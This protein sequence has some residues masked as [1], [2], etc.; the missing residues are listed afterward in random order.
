MPTTNPS[1]YLGIISHYHVVKTLT[2][3]TTKSSKV[4]TYALI[5]QPNIYI[6]LYHE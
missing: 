2:H 4:H 1:K 5:P 3:M 6:F